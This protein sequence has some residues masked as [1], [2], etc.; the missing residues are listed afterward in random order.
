MTDNSSLIGLFPPDVRLGFQRF[1]DG[2]LAE[3]GSDDLTIS[4]IVHHYK[5]AQLRQ[6]RGNVHFC[7]YADLSRDL[8]GWIE[9]L[10][11]ILKSPCHRRL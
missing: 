10:A 8:H 7:H 4:S 11:E 9:R 6:K 1:L 2:P 3:A 5:R